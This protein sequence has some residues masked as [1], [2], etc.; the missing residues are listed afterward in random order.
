[1]VQLEKWKK[2][3]FSF[4]FDWQCAILLFIFH[5][6]KQNR[7]YKNMKNF[8]EADLLEVINPSPHRVHPNCNLAGICGGCQYQH[9]SI[10]SKG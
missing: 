3:P 6:F 7:I 10:E 8:S 4:A 1:M 5:F 2:V 9:M